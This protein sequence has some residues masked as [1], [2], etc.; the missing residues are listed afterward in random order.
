[1]NEKIFN[2]KCAKFLGIF[3]S[4]SD[5]IFVVHKD[6]STP[7]KFDAYYDANDRNMVVEKMLIETR[8]FYNDKAWTCLVSGSVGA[9]DKEMW[10]AQCK[11]IDAVFRN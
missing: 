9:Q 4:D 10:K 7:R 3:Y 6:E 1:M 5:D 11:C 2:L 8:F